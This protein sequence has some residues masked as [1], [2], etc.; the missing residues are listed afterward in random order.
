MYCTVIGKAI[1]ATV[2]DAML[3]KEKHNFTDASETPEN[4]IETS[5]VQ[6]ALLLG[7]CC[8]FLAL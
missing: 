5:E 2:M 6:S 4:R 8:P 7:G 1:V 3:I